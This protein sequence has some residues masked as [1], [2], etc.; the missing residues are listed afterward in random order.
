MYD[1]ASLDFVNYISDVLDANTV[2]WWHCDYN[3]IAEISYF[4]EGV[5]TRKIHKYIYTKNK[6]MSVSDQVILIFYTRTIKLIVSSSV[7]GI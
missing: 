4:Q 1:C 2:I 7:F 5:Y 6:L 3:E